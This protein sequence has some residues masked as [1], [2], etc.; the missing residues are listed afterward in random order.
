M[1]AHDNADSSV[2]AALNRRGVAANSTWA[3]PFRDIR[4]GGGGE[5]DAFLTRLPDGRQLLASLWA[6]RGAGRGRDADRHAPRRRAHAGGD[7]GDGAEKG[8]TAAAS[9][10]EAAAA[11]AERAGVPRALPAAQLRA[12][13]E[14][15][16]DGRLATDADATGASAGDGA[17]KFRVGLVCDNTT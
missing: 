9:R 8:R 16:Q 7:G 1:Q 11:G 4:G 12:V 6:S 17:A 3:L 14:R 5:R 15:A 10:C 2:Y 13:G